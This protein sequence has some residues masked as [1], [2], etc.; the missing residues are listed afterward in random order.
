MNTVIKLIM[1]VNTQN[2]ISI[3]RFLAVIIHIL[4]ASGKCVANGFSAQGYFR[5]FGVYHYF[6][7]GNGSFTFFNQTNLAPPTADLRY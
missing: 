5:I 4:N 1:D 7:L 2:R 3:Y 6:L